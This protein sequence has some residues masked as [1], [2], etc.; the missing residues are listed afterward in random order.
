MATLKDENVAP[1]A[2]T[3][4]AVDADGKEHAVDATAVLWCNSDG[5]G[6]AKGESDDLRQL[7]HLHEPAVL[8]SLHARFD[9]SRIYTW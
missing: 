6:Q 8:Q 1:G 7:A 4:A 2:E 3:L 5:D 9:A